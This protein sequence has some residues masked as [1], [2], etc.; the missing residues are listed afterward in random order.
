MKI[1]QQIIGLIVCLIASFIPGWFGAQFAPGEWYTTIAKPA[2]TPPGYIFGPVWTLLYIMMGVAAWLVWRQAGFSA[3]R[4][5]LIVFIIQL[6]LNGLWSLLFFGWHR[7]GLAF[8]DIIALW[9]MI[10]V[11]IFAFWRH[12]TTA[13]VLLI[14]YFVWVSFASALNFSIWHLNRGT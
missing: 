9:L 3:A 6:I 10:V 2:W 14:P 7:P 4:T 8:I 1:T 5:A 13:G 12:S 11:T